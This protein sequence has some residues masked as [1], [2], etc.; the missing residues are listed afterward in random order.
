MPDPMR[1]RRRLIP[2]LVVVVL[3]LVCPPAWA[4]DTGVTVDNAGP[5][6]KEYAV[7][8]DAARRIGVAPAPTSQATGGPG[9]I[10]LFGAGLSRGSG[11]ARPQVAHGVA[12][13]HHGR[14]GAG[15]ADAR[16]TLR[17]AALRAASSPAASGAPLPGWAS[18]ALLAAAVLVLGIGGGRL[19]AAR[20]RRAA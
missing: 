15:T 8:L 9:A 5:A 16:S 1:P 17:P 2:L 14:P 4:V 7:P 11:T 10:V 18:M 6:G 3:G 13:R 19:A 12:R 20:R